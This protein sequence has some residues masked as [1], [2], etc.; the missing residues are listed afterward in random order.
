MWEPML[1]PKSFPVCYIR[2]RLTFSTKHYSWGVFSLLNIKESGKVCLASVT[3]ELIA[4]Q[5]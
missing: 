3:A 1:L 4:I 5:N 2:M